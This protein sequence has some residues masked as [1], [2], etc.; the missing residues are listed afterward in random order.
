DFALFVQ[1]GLAAHEDDKL[2]GIV[3]LKHFHDLGVT[4]DRVGAHVFLVLL[5]AGKKV[6]HVCVKL[7]GQGID[8]PRRIKP[9]QINR[10]SQDCDQTDDGDY[11]FHKWTHRQYWPRLKKG[12]EM[13]VSAPIFS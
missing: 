8:A 12:S 13:A 11:T 1:L 10:P 4:A 7:R 3:P 9:Y 5:Q 6:V 2:L